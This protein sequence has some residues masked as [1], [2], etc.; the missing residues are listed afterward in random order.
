MKMELKT[1]TKLVDEFIHGH[2]G[3]WDSPWL[4]A[5]ITEELG[6][7]SFSLQRFMGIRGTMCPGQEEFL[8]T[9]V[10]EECGDLFFS[11]ICLTNYLDINLEIALLETLKKFNSRK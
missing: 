10:E 7:L 4:L 1:L 11:L 3:Y 8:K 9:N 2:G 6:E 5:A